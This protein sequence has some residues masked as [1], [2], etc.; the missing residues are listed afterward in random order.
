MQKKDTSHYTTLGVTEAATT[1]EIRT[2]YRRLASQHHPDKGGSTEKF[3]TIQT[4]YATVG[5]PAAREQYDK[6][7]SPYTFTDLAGSMKQGEVEER[8]RSFMS[9]IQPIR[10][11]DIETTVTL[12]LPDILNQQER[13]VAIKLAAGEKLVTVK[14]PRGVGLGKIMRFT[15]LGDQRD[16]T[17]AAGDLY[18][19][20][21]TMLPVGTKIQGDRIEQELL[22]PVLDAILGAELQVRTVFGDD[23][24]VTLHAGLQ[25]TQ[26]LRIRGHG[27]PTSQGRGDLLL[28]P[29]L[30][31]P[32]NLDEHT[33][34][35]LRDARLRA[36]AS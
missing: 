3:Q 9:G 28:K 7:A 33:L 17:K 20:V 36:T 22:V 23:V 11:R 2:A 5:D 25:P 34:Q 14:I 35:L 31:I 30:Q 18:V 21:D 16:P 24:V 8:F 19:R 6:R 15:G 29:I 1:E 32:K 13:I 10:N 26:V 12:T 4:A 27:L